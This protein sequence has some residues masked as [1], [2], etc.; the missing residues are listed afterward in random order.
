MHAATAVTGPQTALSI[1]LAHDDRW[2]FIFAPGIDTF[3]GST[4]FVRV[5]AGLT[6]LFARGVATR[7]ANA[8]HGAAALVV[9]VAITALSLTDGMPSAYKIN[10]FQDVAAFIVF[11]AIAALAV[12]H[13]GGTR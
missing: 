7:L 11:F 6:F 9:L 10:A 13:L 8:F 2:G 12:A 1:S 5:V 3:Q 4:A